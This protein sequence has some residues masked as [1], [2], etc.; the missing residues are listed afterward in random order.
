MSIQK[1]LPVARKMGEENYAAYKTFKKNSKLVDGKIYSTTLNLTGV[2]VMD[3]VDITLKDKEKLPTGIM[4]L[5]KAVYKKYFPR[6]ASEDAKKTVILSSQ[7][8]EKDHVN[9]SI[10]TVTEDKDGVFANGFLH[11]EKNKN[12]ITA[13]I[14]SSCEDVL[15]RLSTIID[16]PEKNSNGKHNVNLSLGSAKNMLFEE[17]DGRTKISLNAQP[18]K[19][20]PLFGIQ[21]EAPNKIFES[22][23]GDDIE[24]SVQDMIMNGGIEI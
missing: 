19:E 1:I 7:N 15:F 12:N 9:R 6:S 23:F 2:N 17:K 4:N 21:I 18:V 24:N 13:N 20:V 16:L 10:T 11:F 14:E 22:I 5:A 8:F 3:A